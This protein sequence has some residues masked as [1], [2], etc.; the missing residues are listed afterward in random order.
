M[1]N[2]R[3]L[4][5]ANV[6]THLMLSEVLGEGTVIMLPACEEVE[7]PRVSCRRGSGV[8]LLAGF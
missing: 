8:T 2:T 4:E 5:A 1:A 7:A 6:L 3:I